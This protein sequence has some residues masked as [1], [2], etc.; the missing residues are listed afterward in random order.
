[1]CIEP[2]IKNTNLRLKRQLSIN[3]TKELRNQIKFS[4]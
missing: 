1:M 2:P 4:N 3:L